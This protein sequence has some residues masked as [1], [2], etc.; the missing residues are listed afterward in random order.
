MCNPIKSSESSSKQK[1]E[2]GF[3][4]SLEVF[5]LCDIHSAVGRVLLHLSD[6]WTSSTL[7]K[8]ISTS[9]LKH[10]PDSSERYNFYCLMLMKNKFLV[11]IKHANEIHS[12]GSGFMLYL[13]FF[14]QVIAITC[15]EMEIPRKLLAG[16]PK[17]KTLKNL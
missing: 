9:V 5:F 12:S 14:I 7:K 4:F 15:R 17:D 2:E 11:N 3:S 8:A 1:V 13:L 10:G 16:V 6:F